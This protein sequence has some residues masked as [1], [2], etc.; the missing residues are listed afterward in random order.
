MVITLTISTQF[1]KDTGSQARIAPLTAA[2]MIGIGN[3]NVNKERG[4]FGPWEGPPTSPQ[5]GDQQQ[6]SGEEG[7][8]RLEVW[9]AEIATPHHSPSH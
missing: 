7:N 9:P 3:A 5:N 4:G 8:E 1:T 2:N 6:Q